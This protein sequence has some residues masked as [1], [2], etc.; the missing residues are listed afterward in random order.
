MVCAFI[1][2]QAPS[3]QRVP[4]ASTWAVTALADISS[5]LS[6][7][8]CGKAARAPVATLRAPRGGAA[9][10]G[11]GFERG[12]R[13]A[14]HLTSSEPALGSK[15]MGRRLGVLIACAVWAAVTAMPAQAAF[16][17]ANGKIAF[18]SFRDGNSEIHTVNA[19]GT[20]NTNLT[21]NPARDEFP[22]WSPDGTK[23]AFT[24]T[25]DDPNPQT[26]T[27]CVRRNYI[28]N[29]DGSNV[30]PLSGV[31][32]AWSPDGAELVVVRDGLWIV[33]ADGTGER[34]L[35]STTGFLEGPDA[36]AWSPDGKW[37]AFGA[38]QGSIWSQWLVHP[39][40]TGRMIFEA[41]T[42]NADWSPDARTLLM[43]QGPG[44]VRKD[45]TGD[46]YH[47][48]GCCGY[49]PAWS[50]DGTKIVYSVQNAD[51]LTYRMEMMNRDGSG[52]TQV[53]P[54]SVGAWRE[55]GPDWQPIPIN[56]YPRP[57]SASPQHISLV[58]AY[59][60]C[61]AANRTHGP[62]LAFPSC[63]P[64]QREPGQLTVGTPDSNGKPAKNVSEV[65]MQVMLGIPSTPA[66][67]ADVHIYGEV[68]DVRLASDL[69]DYTGS[70][71]A[72]VG[73]RI[74]DKSNTPHPGGP[75]AGTV[76]DLTYTFPISCSATADTTVGAHCPFDTTAE[77][78]LPGVATERSRAI[79]Q[80]GQLS[81]H[82]SGGNVFLRQGV[83]VP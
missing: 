63:A 6:S 66:D 28:M 70:L 53:V 16:P 22:A 34:Q 1:V 68:T 57:K 73:L 82:D 32:P 71:E 42:F 45:L 48:Y 37:I 51:G 21:N 67:E 25:R 74:T 9:H 2:A 56:A 41:E 5:M 64:P 49:T 43:D 76:Q 33:D 54:D 59:Q 20:D 81:V 80:L 26:C 35:T 79:W 61:T 50:P 23:I 69:S 65:W 14:A 75:G 39:D 12:G 83:F 47:F 36:P 30:H 31:Q 15:G 8:T 40:D 55:G 46:N 52:V 4:R 10:L 27:L 78:L 13:E 11:V 60:Q 38:E 17:G 77:A 19:D 7:R 44:I 18:V 3:A 72:R 58:P 29:A 24:S 62:P